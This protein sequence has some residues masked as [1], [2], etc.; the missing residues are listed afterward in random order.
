MENAVNKD[1][2]DKAAQSA[3]R[4]GL[5][6][7]ARVLA[8]MGL[9]AVLFLVAGTV[10]VRT[11]STHLIAQVDAQLERASGP[12]F[13]PRPGSSSAGDP[14]SPATNGQNPGAPD[15]SA[16]PDSTAPNG[17][18]EFNTLYV[19]VVKGSTVRTLKVPNSATGDVAGPAVTAA[20]VT[21]AERSGQA[22]TVGATSGSD[23]YRLLVHT[24]A[25]TGDVVVTG[26]LLTDVVN[27]SQRLIEVMAVAGACLLAVLALITWWVL[28][29][30]VRP[31]KEM[32]DAATD[33]AA[34]DLS[35]RI[36][37]AP[38]GTEAADLGDALNVMLSNIQAAFDATAA[39][40]ERLKRFVGD[41][42]H[43]LRTPVT[44]IRGYAELQ[45]AGGLHDPEQLDAA[46]RRIEAES[47]R[48][49]NLVGDLLQLARLDQ[50]RTPRNEPVD[51]VEVA[52][53]A[54][55]D[56]A[57]V[58]QHHPLELDVDTDAGPVP[59]DGDPEQIHQIVANVLGNVAVHTPDGTR[60]SV[61]VT[62]DEETASVVVS[63]DGPGMEPDDAISA[64]ERFHRAD[65]SR[66]R[67][68][69]GSGL[70][71]SIVQAVT[72]AHG[73]TVALASSPGA[74]TRVAMTFPL[75]GRRLR[76]V[77]PVPCTDR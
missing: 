35:Q 42:S 25:G 12:T 23:R 43:E 34:G 44:T 18:S 69:G 14:F 68:S 4:G 29:L 24:D 19:G 10:V 28:R 65:P 76:P 37:L 11:T 52:Q 27:T 73:G 55:V 77:Q 2:P 67:A 48:M 26:L 51:L 46:M 16:A 20:R 53:N 5:T 64:F 72:A 36:P 61:A 60:V 33:I 7:R 22:F 32:T 56:F 63:D 8:A 66:T 74:G 50:G 1:V 49:G 62:C 70:G 41:A 3:P 59:I 40:Q 17:A 13:G 31:I 57:T 71:L 75:A 47:V 6:L 21:A 9:V 38:P 54:S 58:H 15:D 39:S 30:G 45:R